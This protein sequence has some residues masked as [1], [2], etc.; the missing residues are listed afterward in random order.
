MKGYH[1]KYALRPQQ[2]EEGPRGD[3]GIAVVIPSYCE[4]SPTEVLDS[5]W[6]C[7]NPACS[8]EVLVILTT[9]RREPQKVKE[10]QQR[11]FELISKWSSANGRQGFRVFPILIDDL[12]SKHQGSGTARKIG[13]DE[14]VLRFDRSGNADGIIT[15]LDMDCSVDENY[16]QAIEEHFALHSTSPACDI[17]FELPHQGGEFD[18]SV[19]EAAVL[20]E[21]HLRYVIRGLRFAGF[22]YAH[23]TLGAAMAFWASAY[24][25]QSGIGKRKRDELR[26]LATNLMEMGT[27]STLN[28][29]CVHISPRPLDR[30]HAV[31]GSSIAQIAAISGKPTFYSYHPR[32]FNYLRSFIQT[33]PEFYLSNSRLASWEGTIPVI[34]IDFFS[35]Y[36]F[37]ERVREIKANSKSFNSFAKRFFA[38]FN[39]IMVR[40]CADYIRDNAHPNTKVQLAARELLQLENK[41]HP[42]RFS[43]D[44]KLLQY[45]REQEMN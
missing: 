40:R 31:M 15:S 23:H 43:S 20:Y 8:V 45:L 42:R 16:F 14:A 21:I 18:E 1:S 2:I 38:W 10:L 24:K 33:L 17:R 34:M 37:D 29:T 26:H 27:Y 25:K 19:Y 5:L 39:L 28:G 3:L 13:M 12:P 35:G 11:N 4:T 6:R 44:L 9:G 7:K 22:P 32:V 36:F 41:N 30:K